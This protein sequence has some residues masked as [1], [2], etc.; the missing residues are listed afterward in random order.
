VRMRST[1]GT[2]TPRVGT[3]KP[4]ARF[5]HNQTGLDSPGATRGGKAAEP[6]CTKVVLPTSG[7]FWQW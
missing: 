4:I 5:P 6:D 3:R 2:R 1:A 7:L